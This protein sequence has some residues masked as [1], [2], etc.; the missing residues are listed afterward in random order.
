MSNE[1]PILFLSLFL[2]TNFTLYLRDSNSTPN[3][4]LSEMDLMISVQPPPQGSQ[5]SMSS[6]LPRYNLVQLTVYLGAIWGGEIKQRA[7]IHLPKPQRRRGVLVSLVV[8]STV[9][10]TP[11]CSGLLCRQ[12]HLSG[13]WFSGN[14]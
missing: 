11:Q 10:R 8:T 1:D 4:I 2:K 12:V 9:W 5:P 6:N 7:C 13:S 14:E 3:G